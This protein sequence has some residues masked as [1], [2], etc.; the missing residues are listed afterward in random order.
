MK[1]TFYI[2]TSNHFKTRSTCY[3]II[4]EGIVLYCKSNLLYTE[5]YISKQ[6]TSQQ[7]FIV[8][9]ESALWTHY[10]GQITNYK[11]QITEAPQYNKCWNLE[12]LQ[13]NIKALAG[14]CLEEGNRQCEWS[15]S[16]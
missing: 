11:G 1:N 12:F 4:Q 2:A 15:M 13:D 3:I 7:A 9:T 10:K 5:Q 16:L 6:C 8:K 14:G